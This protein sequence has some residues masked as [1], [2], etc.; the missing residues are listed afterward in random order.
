MTLIR[1]R[2]VSIKNQ[3]VTKL[4]VKVAKSVCLAY[5]FY[6][7][8]YVSSLFPSPFPSLFGATFESILSRVKGS[9]KSKYLIFSSVFITK[10]KRSLVS[11]QHVTLSNK[12]RWCKVSKVPFYPFQ[13]AILFFKMVDTPSKDSPV[14][15]FRYLIENV[16][17]CCLH[18]S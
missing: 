7:P 2:A 15:F 14:A 16:F 3:N 8:L 5:I 1:S 11:T 10:F 17:D 18:S 4:F 13:A 9:W 12:L 6:H